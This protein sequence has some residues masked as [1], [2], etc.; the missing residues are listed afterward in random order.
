MAFCLPKFAADEF[1]TRLK[2]GEITPAKLMN[3][4]SEE[5]NAFFSKFLSKEQATATNA[6][7]ESKT[8][9]KNQ[10][11]GMITWAK[12][13]SGIKE[14]ARRELID[15]INR[16]DTV[17]TPESEKAFLADLAEIRLGVGVT[18]Q[19][20]Q[21]IADLAKNVNETRAAIETG[22][23]RLAYGEAKV[24]L[25][26][27]ANGLRAGAAKTTLADIK[28][29]PIKS[30]LHGVAEL[31]GL[32]K[33]TKASLDNS[34]LGRQGL[35]VFWDNPVIWA[36]NAAKSFDTI[37]RQITKKGTSNEVVDAIKADIYSRPN[38]L[39]DNYKRMKLAIGNVEE[40][41]PTSLPERIPL[42]GRVFKASQAAFEGTA[43]RMRAD[44]ADHLIEVA[45]KS[46]VDLDKTQ[47]E[48]IGRF[49][50]SSTGRGSLGSFE[51]VAGE[52]NN[53]FF[54]ARF[55]KSN[56]D[57]V[58]QLG[59]G[60]K[61]VRNKA[62]KRLVKA[63]LG[64]AVVLKIADTINPGSVEWDPRSS[65]FGKIKVGDTRF[66]IT[67]GTASIVTLAA[68]LITQ[69][70]K[71]STTGKI[72]K[73]DSGKYGAPTSLSVI[74]D[75]AINKAAPIIGTVVALR[76]GEDRNKRPVN[77]T[78]KEGALNL[79]K[80]LFAPLPVTNYEELA[81]NPNSAGVLIGSISD[82]LGIGTNTY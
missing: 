15:R 60:S 67:G 29:H 23:D 42:L 16:L 12:T 19:E 27:Y 17:L 38:A 49:I 28:A 4:S 55:F 61:F 22:G 2:S 64:T 34:F 39:N 75:F 50:N 47:L 32:A 3:M 9:L 31:G 20:A 69:S 33:S 57:L 37:A 46:G 59:E 80:D 78:S 82:A 52:V 18:A 30:A 76:K 65:D 71:S 43:Y 13:V 81:A 74:G 62:A 7:F 54:S 25:D 26:N 11:Q 35:K 36:K 77:L 48:S 5:R 8:I 53:L 10:Q 40:A 72:T 45:Q 70:A 73:L 63:V 51:K 66:D 41:Y 1:K 44:L 24:A 58:L 21:K 6:L 56:V 14:P 68:R 79:A